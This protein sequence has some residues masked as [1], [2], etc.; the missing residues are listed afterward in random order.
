MTL[1]DEIEAEKEL[2]KELFR[3]E[4]KN[5]LLAFTSYTSDVYEINW[6]HKFLCRK[7]DQWINGEFTRLLVFMPPQNGKSELVSRRAPAYILGKNPNARIIGASYA[8]SLASRMNRDIQRIMTS[9]QYQEIFPDTTLAGEAPVDPDNPVKGNWTR[10]NGLFEV[11]GHRGSY[12]SAGVGVGI[13][14]MPADYLIIDDPI[15]GAAQA[16][17]PTYRDNLYE[18]Y[19]TEAYARLSGEGRVLVTMTRWHDDDLAGRLKK[20]EQ[21]DPEADKWQVVSFPALKEDDSNPDDPRQIGEALWP[22]RYPVEFL[23]RVRK[24]S[25]RGWLSLYQQTPT[26]TKGGEIKRASLRF[27]SVLPG[28]FDELI[29]SWDLAFKGTARS[30]FVVGQV[31]GRIGARFYLIDQVRDRMN[32][33]KTSEA[34]QALTAKYPTAIK[35]IIE[36]KANGAAIISSLELTISGIIGRLPQGSKEERVDAISPLFEA[37]NVYLPNAEIASWIH[38]YIEELVNFPK[39]KNDDQVDATTQ[40]LIEF[41]LTDQS[42]TFTDDMAAIEKLPEL[43]AQKDNSW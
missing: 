10:N 33:V 32:F 12:R 28:H 14:G 18:W 17:S 6:H 19:T 39:W 25:E 1:V 20:L 15:K 40:A 11:V 16:N 4:S 43:E 29:Q 41:T 34:F 5:S 3:R 24:N 13:T 36:E 30:D 8:D 42:G 22:Q 38:D 23:R 27:Y 2:E 31:W 35:K 7:L 21:V 9:K 37:G 26:S